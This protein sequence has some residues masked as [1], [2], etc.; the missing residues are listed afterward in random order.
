M[1]KQQI[2]GFEQLVSKCCGL[3]VH[4]KE[5]VTTVEGDGISKEL[6]VFPPQ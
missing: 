1:A 5:I 6:T 3:D 2:F 4:K